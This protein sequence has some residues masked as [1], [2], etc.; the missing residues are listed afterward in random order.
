MKKEGRRVTHGR[1]AEG[2]E[3]AEGEN[4]NKHEEEDER[5]GRHVDMHAKPKA[6]E[7]T[8]T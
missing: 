8:Q 7:Q 5:R 4:E 2:N 3:E 1:K 6:D